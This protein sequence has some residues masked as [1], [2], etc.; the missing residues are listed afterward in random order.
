MKEFEFELILRGKGN[1]EVEAY[2]NAIDKLVLDIKHS[3][4]LPEWADCYEIENDIIEG[5]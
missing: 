1:D 5:K 4:H 3:D 2:Y